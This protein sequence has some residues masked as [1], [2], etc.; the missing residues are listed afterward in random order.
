MGFQDHF[1]ALAQLAEI[2]QIRI[3]MQPNEC[4]NF[5]PPD[6]M[7]CIESEAS[8][9]FLIS[10]M[11]Q[12]LMGKLGETHD[13]LKSINAFGKNLSEIE[14]DY[15]SRYDLTEFTVLLTAYGQMVL[16]HTNAADKLHFAERLK[17]DWIKLINQ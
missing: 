14:I 9:L 2:K 6:F 5:S 16:L 1:L 3:W 10:D 15:E 12:N 13:F 4:S 8:L 11:E 7:D 17:I